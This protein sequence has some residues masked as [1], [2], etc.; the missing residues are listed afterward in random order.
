MTEHLFV[1]VKLPEK[2][3]LL[4]RVVYFL[5]GADSNG[6]RQIRVRERMTD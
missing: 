1:N 5:V 3:E 2:R 6:Q 4:E